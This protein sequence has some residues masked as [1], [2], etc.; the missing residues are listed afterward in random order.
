MSDRTE[1]IIESW[2]LVPS[3]EHA[4]S[5]SNMGRVRR[6]TRGRGS[7]PGWIL[8][9]RTNTRGYPAVTLFNKSYRVHRLVALAFLPQPSPQ[10]Q[11]V[12]HK[13][14]IK[15]DNRVENL[16]WVTRSANI[17]HS[18]HVLGNPAPRHRCGEKVP[19]HKLTL[20]QVLA[21]RAERRAGMSFRLIGEKYGVSASGAFYAVK[22]TT[23]KAT[24]A[25][26]REVV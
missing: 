6:D 26:Q 12:N 18:I 22:G 16:E 3:C 2:R 17:L 25:D 1:Q 5:V 20:A 14:G 19:S 8:K 13:N 23:W 7:R 9:S 24:D 4:Y 10:H 21:M 15:T 11:E